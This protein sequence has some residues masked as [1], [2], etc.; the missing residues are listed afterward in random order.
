MKDILVFTDF[1]D[2]AKSAAEYAMHMAIKIKANI[3]LCHALEI[4]EQLTYPLAGHLILQ[5]QTIKRLREIGM[6]MH[7]LLSNSEESVTFCPSIS[8][9]NDLD[10]LSEVAKKVVERRSVDLVVIGSNKPRVGLSRFFPGSHTNDILDNIKCP[11]L[12]IP[13]HASFKGICNITYATD[14]TFDNARVISYLAK[15][16]K[17]LGAEIAVNHIAFLD[18]PLEEKAVKYSFIEQMNKDDI[19][20]SY[21][22]IRED[23]VTQCLIET[24]DPEKMDI[25]TVVHKRYDFFEGLFHSSISKQLAHS[26]KVPLLVMPF[27]YSFNTGELASIH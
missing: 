18:L 2:R 22:T 20:I 24:S 8:Y 6:H 1:S 12:I 27:S 10:S 16:A 15:L 11:V 26:T 14:L 21:N 3:L 23:N 13:E 19:K 25:L 17:P 5:N 7:Q 9:I 4:T